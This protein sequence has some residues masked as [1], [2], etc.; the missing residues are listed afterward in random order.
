MS[1]TEKLNYYHQE[2]TPPVW[3]KAVTNRKQP[4]PF[5][6][7]MW[8][9][10]MRGEGKIQLFLT[11]RHVVHI[12][13]TLHLRVDGW[14]LLA[15]GSKWRSC[16]KFQSFVFLFQF[17][18]DLICPYDLCPC[19]NPL[20]SFCQ[21]SQSHE[22]WIEWRCLSLLE[23]NDI[24]TRAA[25]DFNRVTG[26]VCARLAVMSSD[27][28][29]RSYMKKF[30]VIFFSPMAQQSLVGQDLLIMD[31]SRSHSDTPHSVE[32]LWTSDQSGAETSTWQLIKNIT[33]DSFAT[34]EQMNGRETPYS[35]VTAVA[36]F[37]CVPLW[38]RQ[39]IQ[40]KLPPYYLL[41]FNFHLHWSELILDP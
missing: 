13:T 11:L 6:S 33:V 28:R 37:T 18:P 10:Q 24:Q 1:S 21:K 19:L 20:P 30:W 23:E 9:T 40:V 16:L 22:S 35:Q 4:L 38:H 15:C 27:F 26:H 5:L 31:A 41:Y 39:S 12:V 2:S 25:E 34:T 32:L 8:N 36:T 29:V 14:L 7:I 3:E 17:V